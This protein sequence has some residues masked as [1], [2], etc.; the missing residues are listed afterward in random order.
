MD[1]G[2]RTIDYDFDV[3]IS[4]AS[5]DRHLIRPFVHALE[6]AGLRVWWDQG[7]ITIGDRL[8]EKISQGLTKSRYGIVII[9]PYFVGK[10]WPEAEL[11]SLLARETATGNTVILPIRLTITHSELADKYPLLADIVTA[12]LSEDV[13]LLVKTVLLKIERARPSPPKS[14]TS[15]NVEKVPDGPHQRQTSWWLSPLVVVKLPYVGGVIA[16]VSLALLILPSSVPLIGG[17]PIMQHLVGV[18]TGGAQIKPPPEMDWS[19][20]AALTHPSPADAAG[21]VGYRGPDGRRLRAGARADRAGRRD[22]RRFLRLA[23]HERGPRGS[24]PR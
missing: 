3:F 4:Y 23:D 19:V 7:E 16:A 18:I 21:P 9:S 8:S 15:S 10:H 20:P 11:R 14:P 5:E 6:D 13:S 22:R 24:E 1:P 2:N 12:E 17:E